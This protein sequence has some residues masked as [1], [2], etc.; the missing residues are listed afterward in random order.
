MS[1]VI[2]LLVGIGLGLLMRL[3]LAM[4]DIYIKDLEK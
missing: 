3:F 4:I 2:Y 1:D